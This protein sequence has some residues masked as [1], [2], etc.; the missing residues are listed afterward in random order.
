MSTLATA[1]ALLL[2]LLILLGVRLLDEIEAHRITR[3]YLE[4]ERAEYDRL[5]KSYGRLGEREKR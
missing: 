1:C 4:L 3:K 2:S 5:V